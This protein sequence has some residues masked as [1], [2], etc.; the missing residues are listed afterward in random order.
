MEKITTLFVLL[1]IA[2][3]QGAFAQSTIFG[4]VVDAENGNG[5]PG[6]SVIVKG[7]ITGTTTNSSGNFAMMNVPDDATL[8]ISF[9]G[10]KTVELPVENQTRFNVTLEPDI[11]LL[12][13]VV[14]TANRNQHETVTTAMGIERDPKTLTTSIQTISGDEIRRAGDSNFMNAL[15]GKI[16]GLR[17]YSANSGLGGSTNVDLRGSKALGSRM[18]YVLDGVPMTNNRGD[19]GNYDLGDGLSQLNIHDIESVTVLKSANAAILYGSA[20]AN[21]AILITTKKVN[22]VSQNAST[23]QGAF[24]QRTIMGKII[25]SE[26][27]HGLSG[28][29]IV[30]KETS[31][32]AI[33]DSDGNFVLKVPNDTIIIVMCMGFRTVEIPLEN[34]TWYEI[35]LQPEDL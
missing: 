21:G 8:Q 32:V 6:A 24:G 35:T 34:K 27:G 7:T 12:G 18:L 13:D 16:A 10:Y 3:S 1:L 19:G 9:V 11:Q 2:V 17:V 29:S 26:D 31:T 14:V 30:V 23:Q 5:I 22:V 28:V 15:N 20:G 4:S 25:G 33:T